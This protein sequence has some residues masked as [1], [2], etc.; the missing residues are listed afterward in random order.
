[1]KEDVRT[2][3]K[4]Y[5]WLLLFLLFFFGTVIA[6][7][8]FSFESRYQGLRSNNANQGSHD[9]GGGEPQ[10]DMNKGEKEEK[11][12]KGLDA[13]FL[14][15]RREEKKGLMLASFKFTNHTEQRIDAIT[16]R[17]SHYDES[18][19]TTGGNERTID[20]RLR[21]GQTKSVRYF[22]MGSIEGSAVSAACSVTKVD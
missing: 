8:Q 5:R 21:P 15:W 18:K 6:L 14:G 2:V 12:H 20:V 10:E 3:W 7:P 4:K 13:M 16:V 22:E 19:E 17:C 1:M 9:S 11:V